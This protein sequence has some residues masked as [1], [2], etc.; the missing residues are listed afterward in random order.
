MCEERK[1]NSSTIV[2]TH[3]LVA[4]IVLNHV[5]LVPRPTCAFHFSAAP[6]TR[7]E[8]GDEARIMYQC[9]NR[10]SKMQDLEIAPEYVTDCACCSH[11][12][13]EDAVVNY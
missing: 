7:R 1:F 8:P 13:R 2:I 9:K 6:A 5:S 4:G 10:L 3:F 12:M 11:K